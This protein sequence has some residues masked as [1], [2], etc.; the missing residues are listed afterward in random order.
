MRC[1]AIVNNN[2][3][4][5]NILWS[6]VQKRKYAVHVGDHLAMKLMHSARECSHGVECCDGVIVAEIVASSA[7][8]KHR[9]LRERVESA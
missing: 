6:R 5:L 7:G 2:V 3:C 9:S 1:L 4:L 8:F